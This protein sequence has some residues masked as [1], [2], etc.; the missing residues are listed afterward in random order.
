[1]RRLAIFAAGSGVIPVGRRGA[2]TSRPSPV[3]ARSAGSGYGR[4]GFRKL[5]RPQATPLQYYTRRIRVPIDQGNG[6][7]VVSAAG[8]AT[9][10]VGPAGLGN[11]WFPTMAA[12]STG[13]GPADTSTAIVYVGTRAFGSAQAAQSY[14]GGGDTIGLNDAE[15]YPGLYVIAQWSGA[16]AGDTAVLV[17]Y[18]DMEALV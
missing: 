16:V 11:R 2:R 10:Q 12:I 17:V 5:A 18:G 8:T 14:Q 6:S 3:P 9:V 13:T 1:M 15:L 7:A 4:T